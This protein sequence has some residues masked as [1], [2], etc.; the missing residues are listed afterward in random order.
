MRCRWF[1][2]SVSMRYSVALIAFFSMARNF[3]ILCPWAPAPSGHVKCPDP[4][5]CCKGDSVS[6]C[7]IVANGTC[8]G[9]IAPGHCCGSGQKCCDANTCSPTEGTCCKDRPGFCFAGQK[10]CPFNGCTPVGTTC[11]VDHKHN[12]ST[13]GCPRTPTGPSQCCGTPEKGWC[14]PTVLPSG[15][16][17]FCGKNPGWCQK[18]DDSIVVPSLPM[19]EASNDDNAEMEEFKA[20]LLQVGTL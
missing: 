5:T 18:A 19:L 17:V 1:Y 9:D 20:M 11:C 7:C 4:G 6:P 13:G 16:E 10:C 8:C 14:C 12:R 15:Q 3:A 2:S